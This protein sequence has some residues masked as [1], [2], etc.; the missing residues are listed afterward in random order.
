LKG[1][2]NEGAMIGNDDNGVFDD[3]PESFPRYIKPS[4]S[5][6]IGTVKACAASENEG[7]DEDLRA[8]LTCFFVY[9]QKQQC[10]KPFQEIRGSG[11]S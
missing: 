7:R 4:H 11:G 1:E 3:Q 6:N 8:A 9:I 2:E 10:I 5:I